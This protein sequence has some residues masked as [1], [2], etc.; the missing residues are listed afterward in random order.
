MNYKC[1]EEEDEEEEEAEKGEEEVMAM[2]RRNEREE[3]N[4]G[5]LSYGAAMARKTCGFISEHGE[6][7]EERRLEKRKQG[8]RGKKRK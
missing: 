7:K 8:M 3:N 6:T 4:G 1:I 2:S 5:N